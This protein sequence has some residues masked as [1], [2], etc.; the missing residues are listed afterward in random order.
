M[1]NQRGISQEALKLIACASMLADHVGVALLPWQILRIIGRLAFP[2][3]A[4]LL[5]EG[6]HHTKH[7]Y[8]YMDRIL[9]CAIVSELP[10]DMAAFGTIHPFHQNTMLT[11]LLGLLALD[12]M[13]RIQD[14][15]CKL[16]GLLPILYAAARI[17]HADYGA[18]GVALIHLLALTRDLPH[19]KMLQVL[20]II[21]ICGFMP[22]N[23][24]SLLGS[25]ISMELFGAVSA[26]PIAM[27]SGR[28][29]TE[30]KAVQ[31]GFYL[32]YPVHLGILS[33]LRILYK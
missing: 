4:Y 33:L 30:S 2:I 15:L 20:S 27:Y 25:H 28:K 14:T 8:R 5:V 10:F 22:S 9:I 29:R 6:F 13:E 3:Y 23:T 18:W 11:L 12:M 16:L 32:F 7:R 24:V 26:I 19:G 17:F 1:R 31:T 21:M